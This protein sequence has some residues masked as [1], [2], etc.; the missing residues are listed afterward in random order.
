MASQQTETTALI[1]R[2]HDIVEAKFG[3]MKTV[4]KA[5]K[6]RADEDARSAFAMGSVRGSQTKLRS[7]IN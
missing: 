7:E 6:T 5:T 1:V 4:D 2:K 3:K